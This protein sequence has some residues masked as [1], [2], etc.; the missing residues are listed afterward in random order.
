MSKAPFYPGWIV[1]IKDT[2]THSA[3]DKDGPSS[4]DVT[5]TALSLLP[6]TKL[7]SLSRDLHKAPFRLC[8]WPVHAWPADGQRCRRRRPTVSPGLPGKAWEFLASLPASALA[9]KKTA[10]QKVANGFIQ[11]MRLGYCKSVS[12][13]INTQK[14][15]NPERPFPQSL[16]LPTHRWPLSLPGL[17][18]ASLAESRWKLCWDISPSRAWAKGKRITLQCNS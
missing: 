14:S 2:H 5:T 6:V 1:H 3:A 13:T 12:E 9:W 18:A 7:G 8:L 11:F 10:S 16:R 4:A 17:W 15:G